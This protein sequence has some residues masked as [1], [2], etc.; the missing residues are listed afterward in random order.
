MASCMSNADPPPQLTQPPTLPDPVR[1]SDGAV[2]DM[3]ELGLRLQQALEHQRL[4]VTQLRPAQLA[5]QNALEGILV[6]DNAGIVTDVNPAFERMTGFQRAEVVGRKASDLYRWIDTPGLQEEILQHLA[7][8][9]SWRGSALFGRESGERLDCLTSINN[10]LDEGGQPVGRV[11]VFA[12]ITELRAAERLLEKTATTD[13]LTGLPN[14][15]KFDQLLQQALEVAEREGHR[16]AVYFVDVD[17]FK[18]INDTLG[19][20]AGDEVLREAARTMGSWMGEDA[21]LCRRSGDEFLAFQHLTLS[22]EEFRESVR[23]FRPEAHIDLAGPPATRVTVQF[24]SGVALYPDDAQDL[25]SLFRAADG[26]LYAA[27]ERGRNCVEP[28][29]PDI[30]AQTLRRTQVE[31][32]L[33]Q[34]LN[35]GSLQLAYQPQVDV[36]TRKVLA[37]EALCRWHDTELGVVTPAEFVAVA[38]DGGLAPPL[39]RFV[40]SQVLK[41]LPALK[42]RWPQVRVAI[43]TSIQEMSHPDFFRH[44]VKTLQ[45]AGPS[46]AHHLEIEITEHALGQITPALLTQLEQLRA[47]GCKVSMD[48]FGT[49]HSSLSRLHQLPLDKIKVDQSFVRQADDARVQAILRA[50]V[51]MASALGHDLVFEGVES[52]ASLQNLQAMGARVVQ[53]YA[54]GRPAALSVWTDAAPPVG[55]PA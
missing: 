41:D 24:S 16:L 6:T 32:R 22:A 3:G 12:D 42:A 17:H 37:F 43:N 19:H 46:A 21:V 38:L 14:A 25:E 45:A 33:A 34:A 1:P 11:V 5:M 30:G 7:T 18:T 39:G 35:D 51:E 36:R 52:E 15:L 10:M 26:A 28:F 2:P 31:R 4:L 47:I 54:V 44:L 55:S 48:D 53:G 13:R 9:G 20:H 23:S 27:K 50:M 40:L 8:S 49:G 29:T